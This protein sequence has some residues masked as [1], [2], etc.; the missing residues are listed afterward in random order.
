MAITTSTMLK[1]LYTKKFTKGRYKIKKKKKK[2][3]K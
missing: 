3:K 2:R 1:E